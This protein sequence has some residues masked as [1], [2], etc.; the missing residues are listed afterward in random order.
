MSVVDCAGQLGWQTI[1]RLQ[2]G[3]KFPTGG[4]LK[5]QPDNKPASASVD[6]IEENA[7]GQQIRFD[8]GADGW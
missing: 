6:S 2:G 8:A 5:G 3:V 7:K 4:R 1:Q